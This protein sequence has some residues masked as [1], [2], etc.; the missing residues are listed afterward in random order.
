M[1][2]PI[3]IGT[4]GT[5]F[6]YT[7]DTVG[8]TISKHTTTA[9]SPAAFYTVPATKKFIVLSMKTGSSTSSNN[10]VILKVYNS[11]G[12]IDREIDSFGGTF[13]SGESNQIGSAQSIECYE[14]LTAGESLRLYCNASYAF[15]TVFGVET[16]A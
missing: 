3:T 10:T 13:S 15:T 12:G 7:A 4:A 14:E 8:K 5:K 6:I 9:T 11:G 1:T 16:S 2:D